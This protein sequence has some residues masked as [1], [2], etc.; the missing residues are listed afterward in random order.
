MTNYEKEQAKEYG[1]YARSMYKTIIEFVDHRDMEYMI[2]AIDRKEAEAMAK[3]LTNSL[4]GAI[5]S[6]AL[7]VGTAVI[8]Q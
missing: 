1:L 3:E 8:R 2:I 7:E 4:G 6:L 5:K